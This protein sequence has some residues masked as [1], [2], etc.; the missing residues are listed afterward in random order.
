[1]GVEG[2]RARV[3]LCPNRKGARSI[4]HYGK[5]TRTRARTSGAASRKARSSPMAKRNLRSEP[6]RPSGGVGRYEGSPGNRRWPIVLGGKRRQNVRGLGGRGCV[7]FSTSENDRTHPV[8]GREGH[9]GR[10]VATRRPPTGFGRTPR[11]EDAGSPRKGTFRVRPGQLGLVGSH[12][13]TC[14]GLSVTRF[15]N[16]STVGGSLRPPFERKQANRLLATVSKHP[17]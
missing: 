1:M 9:G 6:T 10:R 12:R 15:P 14:G 11:V 17:R 2:F 4:Q 16:R 7:P 3:Q 8:P 13:R 5:H